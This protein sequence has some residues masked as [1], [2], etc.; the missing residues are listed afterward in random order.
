MY[1]RAPF[2][3]SSISEHYNRRMDQCLQDLPGMKRLVDDVIIYGRTRTEFLQR[4]RQFLQR[5]RQHGV[6]LNRAK[7]QYM[8]PSVKF[9]GFIVSA[10]GYRPDPELTAAI[11][12]FP[13]PTEISALRSFFG[14]VN[15]I[16]PFSDSVARHLLPLRPLLS[17][18]R[19]FCW[20]ATHQEAF[21]KARELLSSPTTLAFYNLS[22]PTRLSTDASRLHGFGFLLEQKQADGEW[23]VVQAGSRFV[24]DTE[25]RYAAIELELAAVVWAFSKCRLFLA[26]IPHFDLY[27]DH[28]PLVPIINR[29][30]LDELENPRLQR[31]KLKLA[32]FGPFTAH[33]VKGSH[34]LAADALSRHPVAAAAEGDEADKLPEDSAAARVAAI[35]KD[36]LRVDEVRAAAD[37]DATYQLL[38][39]TVIAG[40]PS[41]K[42]DLPVELR[43]YWP[44]HENLSVDDGLVV[45]GRRLVVPAALRQQVLHQ[46]HSSH[47]AKEKTKQR[48]RQIIFWPGIDND[49]ENVVRRCLECQ[50]DLPSLPRETLC[51]R[52]APSRPFEEVSM[53]FG[54]Y[55]GHKFL[56]S[57]D[58]CSGWQFVHDLGL[59]ARTHQLIDAT[60]NI[61][62][63]AGVFNTLWTDGGPQF[64]AKAF[65][66]FLRQWGV[67]HRTSSPEYPQSNGRAEAAVKATKKLIRRCWDPQSR[68]LD[69]ELWTRGVLQHRNTPGPSGRSPAEVLYGH[70]VRDLLPA[71]RRNFAAEWQIAADQTETAAAQRQERIEQLYNARA[72][73][74]PALTVGTHVAVQ[75]QE[76]GRWD[77]YGTIVEVGQHRRYFIRMQSGRVLS[78]NRR[79]IRRRYGHAIPDGLSGASAPLGPKAPTPS[80]APPVTPATTA[81]GSAP[82]PLTAPASGPST[83]ETTPQQRPRRSQ[84]RRRRPDRFVPM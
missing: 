83:A 84:R 66:D 47:L 7:V 9:A 59:H 68:Q 45:Y 50:R 64:R 49:I 82:P 8:L 14:L 26:G 57:V 20:D 19:D 55:G 46:L 60:R 72:A 35:A 75:N 53:D 22:L 58:H 81:S 40:F 41:M 4:V 54:D 37:Q 25:F 51:H 63:Y 62:C 16:A 78:R 27:V 73:D 5:C 69:S 21:L 24:T 10:D 32:E 2:G 11:R 31:L 70:P 34:H 71:H 56:I 1:K 52:P 61:F 42:A 80:A 33:W 28:R 65:Q 44:V 48:A 76:T 12:N 6:S 43:P 13:A 38:K 30:M 17:A 79:H 15:Q 3:V 23:R 36:D 74:L 77:R 67:T 18:K 29:K 39:Q